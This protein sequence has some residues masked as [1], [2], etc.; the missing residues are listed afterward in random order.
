[1]AK[2][3]STIKSSI[4]SSIVSSI[5]SFFS[6]II[7]YFMDEPEETSKP[8]RKTAENRKVTPKEQYV[9]KETY[10]TPQPRKALTQASETKTNKQIYEELHQGLKNFMAKKAAGSIPKRST[11]LGN[12]QTPMNNEIR[13]LNALVAAEKVSKP[14]TY[15][16][17]SAASMKLAQKSARENAQLDNDIL[18]LAGIIQK[19][20]PSS[21]ASKEEEF[22]S[23]ADEALFGD[24][25]EERHQEKE[26]A[27]K[28]A[29]AAKNTTKLES[30]RPIQSEIIEEDSS[31]EEEMVP[32][33]SFVGEGAEE[34]YY[35]RKAEY[36]ARRAVRHQEKEEAKKAAVAAKSTTKVETPQP[37]QPEIVREDS[38]SEEQKAAVAVESTAKV[39]TV[40][41]KKDAPKKGE[42]TDSTID[43][44]TD[45][46]AE[47][48]RIEAN[49]TFT[50]KA[51]RFA[52]NAVAAAAEGG[53]N[54]AVAGAQYS[55]LAAYDLAVAG[56][57]EGIGVAQGV[58]KFTYNV[59]K[60]KLGKEKADQVAAGLLTAAQG[61]V[62]AAQLGA[63]A[64]A[65]T[66][67]GVAKG[68]N[69][70]YA[71][72]ASAQGYGTF[73][74]SNGSEKC[75]NQC[76][77]EG[78]EMLQ[79]SGVNPANLKPFVDR[80]VSPEEDRW[81]AYLANGNKAESVSPGSIKK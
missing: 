7:S 11:T 16:G 52:Y 69:Y 47:N 71:N 72:M 23:L 48:Q 51:K 41:A 1:M 68:A 10:V 32:P 12:A 60:D 20:D 6:S 35:V 19:D 15:N 59:A 34:A 5:S 49:K 81:T 40:E 43:R 2:S 62:Q 54:L 24:I 36:D 57:R 58:G 64:A 78:W 46:W 37:I 8:R 70:I 22:F 55:R 26:E 33:I 42:L 75:D 9:G 17:L 31:S 3:K 28:A 50:D 13:T 18:D 21:K 14:P 63:Q 45:Q 74:S 27:K 76:N 56:V 44:Q 80:K 39:E 73:P 25:R 79:E 61:G 4:F 30:P 65:V 29:V 66:A 53:R 67:Q 38:S 77:E